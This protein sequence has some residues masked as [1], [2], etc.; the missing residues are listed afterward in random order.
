MTTA[1][2]FLE[3]LRSDQRF[4]LS[5]HEHPDGDCLGSQVGLYHLMKALGR[6]C[7]IVNPDPVTAG[8]GAP[9]YDGVRAGSAINRYKSGSVTEPEMR[10]E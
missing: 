6:D 1:P 7:H 8:Y 9:A 4:L 3:F 2:S 5:G 10:A